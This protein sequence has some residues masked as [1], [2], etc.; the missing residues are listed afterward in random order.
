MSSDTGKVTGGHLS[1]TAYLYVRQST[2]Y[3][4]LHNT[5]SGRRQYDLK[6]RAV[7]LGWPLSRVHVIDIDQGSSGASADGRA[8]FQQLVAG[9]SLG[10]AGIVLGLECSRLARDNADW[11][12]LIKLCALNGTL[13]CDEDG[14]YDPADPNDRLLLGMKG[15]ISEFELHYLKA[16]MRGGL[17]AKAGRGELALRLPAGLCYDAAGTVMPDPDTGVRA[18]VTR[19]FTEFQTAGSACG[20]ARAFAAQHL[21]FP[22]RSASGE[23]T[24]K[25]LTSEQAAK[26][27]RNPRYAG[28]YCYGRH[29]HRVA[30]GRRSSAA[31]PR[32][33]WTVLIP[34]AHDG[35]ITWEQFEANQQVLDGNRGGHRSAGPPREGTALLQG[36]VICGTCGR[37]MSVT[38]HT[39]RDSDHVPSY[40]CNPGR[41]SGTPACQGV[42]G[43]RIDDAVARL[44]IGALTPAAVE[45][46]LEVTAR[47]R[48]D[49]EQADALRATH[50]QRART[51]ADAARRRYLAVDPANRLVAD[52]LEAD[53]N[54]RLRDLAQAEDD[55]Q[56]A[57]REAGTGPTPGQEEQAR[58]LAADLPAL[59]A[60][61]ATTMKDRKRLIRLLVTDITL[62]KSRDTITVHVRLPGGQL[63]A[64]TVPRPLR[65]WE[66][67]TTPQPVLDLISQLLDQHPCHEVAAILTE[68]GLA[69]GRGTPFTSESLAALC[70]YHAIPGHA[71][72]MRAAGMLTGTELAARLGVTIAT[73]SKWQRD[74]LLDGHRV[75]ARGTH[76]YPPGQQA[77]ARQAR[78]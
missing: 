65:A 56:R 53:W 63:Q 6:G 61:P 7:A 10:R 8:G 12:Q 25:P 15:Q 48:A 52:A 21:A 23:L 57:S 66:P 68:R 36:L 75:D 47:L 35:Y 27:L 20:T 32:G 51:A 59:W 72:R 55:Y 70:K 29:A 74:G 50:V 45:A 9:V 37:K 33:E 13:I 78:A 67:I 26:V 69:G 54:T 14:L 71:Q 58:A 73:I 22:A 62:L 16:R 43:E 24:W 4:V 60:S 30:A 41:D 39:R 3:Q 64:L 2:V 42:A 28:A 11:Q 76:L 44:V 77:P 46:A 31:R 5:E 17:L 18:A 38:Y 40:T 34:G 1:R 49:A 19:L